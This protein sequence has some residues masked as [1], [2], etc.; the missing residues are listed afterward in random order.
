MI[1]MK[2]Y[3]KFL[4]GAI[5]LVAFASC[6][7]N[8][9]LDFTPAVGKSDSLVKLSYLNNYDVLKNYVDRTV[10]PNFKLGTGVDASDYNNKGTVYAVTVGNFDEMT[11]GNAM[12]YGSCVADNG[13]M[14]F[15]TVKDFVS[16]AKD[17]GVSIYG[18]TLAWHSQ[19]N[20]KY[21]NSLVPSSERYLHVN[22][23]SAK[24]NMWDWSLSYKLDAPLEIGQKYT[25]TFKAKATSSMN[26]CFWPTDGV[27]YPNTKTQYLDQ[28]SIGTKWSQQTITFTASY[29]LKVLAYE[30][31]KFGGDL[32][33]DDFSLVK[34]GSTTNLIANP[35]FDKT[36]ISHYSYNATSCVI[37]G[38]SSGVALTDQQKKDTLTWA[39]GNWIEGM[40][41]A[42]K[43]YVKAWDVVNEPLSGVD[44]DG[45]GFYDLQSAT[46][47]TVS[48]DDASAN[49]YWQDYLGDLDYVRTAVADARKYF[50]E[51][52]GNASDLKL[53]INDYNLESDWDQ[54][55]KLISLINWISKWE[56]DGTTTIDGIGTQMHV[57]YKEDSVQ[58]TSQENAIVNMFKL[59]AA[60]K[61]LVRISELD[62]GILDAN[63]NKVLT[64]NVTDAQ[65]KEQAA[66]YQFIVKAYFDNVPAAQRYG[67]AQW[68]QTDSPSTTG[69]WRAN[70][71][72][73][74]W[75]SNY[76]R[77]RAYA[78]F[79]DG[80]AGKVVYTAE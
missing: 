49:F 27:A 71:P 54:N 36:D 9:S 73:G 75:N 25:L 5:S 55:K 67:I 16:T 10:N 14:D 11:A 6:A 17:A 38:S 78:G 68:A 31:G 26:L 40:M 24:T 50:V 66:F 56:A 39:M 29:S 45:D 30:F 1:N 79:A 53:F 48:D 2:Y 20:N 41:N 32:Y 44:K 70:E 58:Q 35:G 80:L 34:D 33:L 42:C 52:G 59:M 43:G 60:T 72:I 13:S 8:N 12:K 61:K 65:L 21:L 15:G 47:G 69:A 46:R 51:S 23:S 18:H 7:D 37:E 28:L 63:G 4:L 19:Q 76:D 74:L 57:S 22:T 3:N 62:M 64:S 77:K